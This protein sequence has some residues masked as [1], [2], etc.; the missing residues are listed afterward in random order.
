MVV[1][2]R[3]AKPGKFQPGVAD[4]EYNQNLKLI[5]DAGGQ[6]AGGNGG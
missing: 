3:G 6:D 1:A 4:G 5:V 2:V